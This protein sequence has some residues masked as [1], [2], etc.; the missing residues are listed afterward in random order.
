MRLREAAA[1]GQRDRYGLR[2]LLARYSGHVKT[3]GNPRGLEQFCKKYEAEQRRDKKFVESGLELYPFER[4]ENWAFAAANGV[5]EAEF[6]AI[7]SYTGNFYRHINPAIWSGAVAKDPRMKT[8]KMVMDEGMNKLPPFEGE[9]IRVS[10]LPEAVLQQ[11]EVGKVVEY[12]AYT[13]T[14]RKKHWEMLGGQKKI[15]YFL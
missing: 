8:Y 5:T 15:I 12:Q 2:R 10:K 1:K 3:G 14:S 6:S 13:S 7:R 9:V 4:Q 11:H